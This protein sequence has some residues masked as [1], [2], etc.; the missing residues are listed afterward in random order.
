MNEI[1]V[2]I[3][4]IN[5]GDIQKKL[6]SLGAKKI[7]EGKVIGTAFDV[8]DKRFSEKEILVILRKLGTKSLLTIKKLL[9]TN[10]AKVSEETEVEVNDYDAME[11]IL[12]ILGLR[13]KRGYP[14]KKHR[15]SYKLDNVRFEIDTFAEF[16]TYLEIEAPSIEI[17]NDHV[18]KLG[19]SIEDTKPWGTR[20]V[21]AHYR[22]AK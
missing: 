6:L 19:L 15:I 16:P 21:F 9:N 13:Q 5:R 17:I 10:Q 3:L 8:P 2:K 1:E 11:K 4:E 14:L 12:V 18:Q 20:E 22:N 7:F